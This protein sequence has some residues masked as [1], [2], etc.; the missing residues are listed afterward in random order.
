M[1][2]VGQTFIEVGY[3]SDPAIQVGVRLMVQT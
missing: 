3:L 2:E 1:L